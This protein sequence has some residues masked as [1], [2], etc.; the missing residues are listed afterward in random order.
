M[1]E[2]TTT[3]ILDTFF[4]GL[5]YVGVDW[6]LVRGRATLGLPGRDVDLLV[7]KGHLDPFEDLVFELG[8]LMLPARSH[9]WHRFY[10][11]PDRTSGT[12]VELDVVTELM[13]NRWL[14]LHSG[15]ED[16]CLDRRV[17]DRSLN[18]LD[19]ADAF[20]TVLLH[21]V[22]DK[23]KV[24]DRRAAEL[25]EVVD[26]VS[27]PSPGEEIFRALCPPGWSPDRAV[28]CV[29]ER[30]WESLARLGRDIAPPG[31][32][33]PPPREAEQSPAMTAARRAA[34][35]VAR[36]AYPLLWRRAGLGAVP[37]VL[38][39]L[40]AGSVDT[41][42]LSLRRRPALCEVLV[43]VADERRSAAENL[44]R[45]DHYVSLAGGWNRL[46]SVGLEK[47]RLH[48]VSDLGL[49]AEAYEH[50]RETSFRVAGRTR[51]RR[52]AGAGP[53]GYDDR[54]AGSP[55]GHRGSLAASTQANGRQG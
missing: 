37:H 15:L 11:V 49:S 2:R 13:Y 35:T 18:V 20:W 31:R 1:T 46:T 24:T 53:W 28:A 8:G 6:A 12:Q 54:T 27:R 34:R 10:L 38:D 3:A 30:D 45:G 50:L 48:S 7:R 51:C 14:R 22:L 39:V 41:T 36:T 42:V 44:L 21:C 4:G 5:E 23:Q 17:K 19:P 32:P 25:Q 26:E 52:A 55:D 33:T 16:G 29:R 47:V 40:E 9:P 43:L